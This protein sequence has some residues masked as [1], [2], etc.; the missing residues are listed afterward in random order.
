M[1]KFTIKDFSLDNIFN[2]K[3]VERFKDNDKVFNINEI[4]N[5]LDL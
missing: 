1:L 3:K 5:M 4:H 2:L